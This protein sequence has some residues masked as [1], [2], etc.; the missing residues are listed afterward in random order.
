[1]E[2]QDFG[3]RRGLGAGDSLGPI[4]WNQLEPKASAS[5]WPPTRSRRDALPWAAEAE[6]GGPAV[7]ITITQAPRPQNR[8]VRGLTGH[9]ETARQW[10]LNRLIGN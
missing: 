4:Y 6:S 9:A 8:V 10:S 1:M 7:S 3:Q 5:I 2:S